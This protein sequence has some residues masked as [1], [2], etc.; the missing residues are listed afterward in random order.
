MLL[1]LARKQ[2]AGRLRQ[3]TDSHPV[4]NSAKRVESW[5]YEMVQQ[6]VTA[7]QSDAIDVMSSVFDGVVVGQPVGARWHKMVNNDGRLY[8]ARVLECQPVTGRY[9]LEYIDDGSVEWVNRSQFAISAP[10]APP[11]EL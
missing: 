2:R 11:A 5:L 8:Q 3:I 10:G 1:G 4:H 7:L 6:T 9:L